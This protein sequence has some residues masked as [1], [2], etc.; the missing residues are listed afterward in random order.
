MNVNEKMLYALKEI[1]GCAYL[2]NV[3]DPNDDI[4][5]IVTDAVKEAES[6]LRTTP[7]GWQLVP[8]EPTREMWAA[9]GNAVGELRR[10]HGTTELHHDILSETVY[11]AMIEAAGEEHDA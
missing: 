6:H 1:L 5:Q 4:L 7:E 8:I 9:S 2:E 10:K 3:E 11:K